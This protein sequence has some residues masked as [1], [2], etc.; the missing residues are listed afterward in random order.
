MLPCQ[1]KTRSQTRMGRA[2]HALRPAGFT[3]CP[4][5]GASKPHHTACP[6]CGYVRP[7]SS[8]QTGFIVPGRNKDE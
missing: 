2:H 5:C 3:R 4:Q 8:R 1:R 7:R 6:S